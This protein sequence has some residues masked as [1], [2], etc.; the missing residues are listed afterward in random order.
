MTVDVPFV[1][2][3]A[4]DALILAVGLTD[5]VRLRDPIRICVS[6]GQGREDWLVVVGCRLL[7]MAIGREML[8][9][10]GKKDFIAPLHRLIVLGVEGC[11]NEY[12]RQGHSGVRMTL[13]NVA[14]IFTE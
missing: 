11:C 5:C 3:H 2:G 10:F 7:L 9:S 13:A 8:V 14:V 4:Y 1:S 6:G 12:C